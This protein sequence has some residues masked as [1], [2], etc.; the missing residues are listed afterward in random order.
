MVYSPDLQYLPLR[1]W[2]Q[3]GQL[4]K[5]NG[6]YFSR[7]KSNATTG[8]DDHVTVA[9]KAPSSGA[10][11]ASCPITSSTA[12]PKESLTHGYGASA[13]SNAPHNG[14]KQKRPTSNHAPLITYLLS[15]FAD[16]NTAHGVTNT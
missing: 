10:F 13:E 3:L 16:E 4:F 9:E 7:D 2:C 6:P 14:T 1:G 5:V 15:G 12:A 8:S 11:A